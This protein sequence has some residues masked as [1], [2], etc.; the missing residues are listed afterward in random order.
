MGIDRAI[1]DEGVVRITLIHQLLARLD[2]S[3]P[4]YQR[5]QDHEFGHRQREGRT[6]PRSGVT[7]EIEFEIVDLKQ[8][9]VLVRIFVKFQQL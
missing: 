2:V 4:A 5:V 6:V 9:F 8:L 3:G 1:R 7:P